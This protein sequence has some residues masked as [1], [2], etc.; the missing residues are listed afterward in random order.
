MTSNGAPDER[1]PYL[2]RS[3]AGV[4]KAKPKGKAQ[5]RREQRERCPL[6][7]EEALSGRETTAQTSPQILRITKE[8]T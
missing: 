8:C 1:Y 5:R 6:H 4:A 7:N 3:H 2:S